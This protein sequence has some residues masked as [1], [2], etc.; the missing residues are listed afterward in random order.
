MNKKLLKVSKISLFFFAAIA[1]TSVNA[2]P[3]TTEVT[4]VR[5]WGG[6]NYSFQTTAKNKCGFNWWIFDVEKNKGYAILVNLA[7]TTGKK[8]II[9]D[10]DTK[11]S[12]GTATRYSSVTEFRVIK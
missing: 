10:K 4:L 6:S 2:E 5:S 1:T 3:Y 11:C 8:I 7:F 12:G 9:S